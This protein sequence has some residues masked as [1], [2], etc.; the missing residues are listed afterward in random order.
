[1][2]ECGQS[3]V[4]AALSPGKGPVTHCTEGWLGPKAGLDGFGKSRPLRDSIPG[5]SAP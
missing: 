4:P 5:P 3:H 1:M 2:G